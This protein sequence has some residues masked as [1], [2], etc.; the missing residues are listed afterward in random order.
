MANWS[1][2]RI[3]LF[4]VLFLAMLTVLLASAILIETTYFNWSSILPAIEAD[5]NINVMTEVKRM[6]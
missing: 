1:K 2:S 6:K 3:R 4:F 5:L